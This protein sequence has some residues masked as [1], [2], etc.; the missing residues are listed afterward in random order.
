MTNTEFMALFRKGFTT[1]S[2]QEG[3]GYG[4]YNILCITERYH[5][6]ILTRNE[7]ISEENYVVFG[8]LLP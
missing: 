6:K 5:G 3:R 4:L 1:K 2:S 8:V 7:R